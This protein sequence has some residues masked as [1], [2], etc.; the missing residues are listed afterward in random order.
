M[1]TEAKTNETN[2][3]E[4]PPALFGE[5]KDLDKTLFNIVLM[6]GGLNT[7]MYIFCNYSLAESCALFYVREFF[8]LALKARGEVAWP[9]VLTMDKIFTKTQRHDTLLYLMYANILLIFFFGKGK[10][11]EHDPTY[12]TDNAVIE[13]CLTIV[14]L[15]GIYYN[16]Y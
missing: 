7:C 15:V 1:T 5:L 14:M 4:K 13:T 9:F 12:K 6:T 11:G 10:L 3:H 8:F 2:T 16:F